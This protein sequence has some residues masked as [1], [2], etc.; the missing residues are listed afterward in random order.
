MSARQAK[1]S[2]R[3]AP[4]FQGYFA[5]TVIDLLV[6]T[7]HTDRDFSLLIPFAGRK[8]P[9]RFLAADL[10]KGLE[11]LQGEGGEIDCM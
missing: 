2:G 4:V 3:F 8:Y 10:V 5:L 6:D 7:L 9:F 1:G 11:V